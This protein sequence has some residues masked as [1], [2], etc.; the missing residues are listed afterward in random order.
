MP[1]YYY[2][3]HDT[4]LSVGD[5]TPLGVVS[6]IT[7]RGVRFLP[8]GGGPEVS[9]AGAAP[10]GPVRRHP[11]PGFLLYDDVTGRMLRNG[12][13]TNKGSLITAIHAD[14]ALLNFA[15]GDSSFVEFF[16]SGLWWLHGVECRLNPAATELR[17]LPRVRAVDE[18]HHVTMPDGSTLPAAEAV[19][20]S[21]AYHPRAD[22]QP[23][24]GI[25]ARL[26]R[27][28]DPTYADGGDGYARLASSL[29]VLT[30]G[31]RD[32][33]RVAADL[34]VATADHHLVLLEDATEVRC[35]DGPRYY[36][37]VPASVEE[38]DGH[39]YMP[40]ALC[41]C[42]GSGYRYWTRETVTI[43][44]LRYSR[45]WFDTYGRFCQECNH[46]YIGT[47][48]ECPG[49]RASART[50][51]RGYSNRTATDLPPEEDVP[52]K[53]GIELEVGCDRGYGLD[54]CTPVMADALDAGVGGDF[55]EYAV[56]K[57]DGSLESCNGFEIVTRPDS[58]R[59]HKRVW[60][61]ALAEASVRKHLS[62]YDNGY[63]GMH[64]HVSREPLSPLWVGRMLV[65]LNS[66][67]CRPLVTAVAGRPSNRYTTFGDK[68][69]TD[70]RFG[71]GHDRYEALNTSGTHTVEF[72]IFRG[73]LN[74]ESFIKNI[75]FVEAV[76]D[77]CRPA[78]R[79]LAD[80]GDPAR[81]MEFVSKSRSSYPLLHKFLIHKNITDGDQ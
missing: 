49:C 24:F 54:R 21:G 46:P 37:T 7:A 17:E 15:D 48:P 66:E 5:T 34:A 60:N 42:A 62:S 29:A 13:V 10:G 79:S 32:G 11:W 47:H 25:T 33:E 14:C 67:A 61:G 69:L 36:Y 53:F 58:P 76:I 39:L 56:F 1:E 20:V 68:K 12:D 6:A 27:R 43:D 26:V 75:E 3:Y 28:D 41:V 38:L 22:Y 18:A 30:A 72:R 55:T 57:H 51:I 23:Y 74:R 77:F 50:R 44:G 35:A 70:G 45:G 9:R 59:V 52:I 78:S 64:I 19:F 65:F 16:P 40:N 80:A 81:F 71:R 2:T 31:A 8:T 63:C 4:I 73:T